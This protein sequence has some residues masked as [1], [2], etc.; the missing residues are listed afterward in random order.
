MKIVVV[1]DSH[2]RRKILEKIVEWNP[3]ADLFLHCGDLCDDPDN[4]PQYQFCRGN[5]DSTYKMP[6]ENIIEV[7]GHRI[8]LVHSHNVVLFDRE[9]QLAGMAKMNHCDI[10]C[11]GHTHRH[12]HETKDGITLLNPGSCARPRDQYPA[13]Y[14]IL[15]LTKYSTKVRFLYEGKDWNLKKK[16]RIF[17]RKR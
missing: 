7:P 10:V 12:H 8:L 9:N 5:C 1:S 4:Y 3:D 15:T 17:K 11:Y 2:G 6:L 14:A 16:S 13:S